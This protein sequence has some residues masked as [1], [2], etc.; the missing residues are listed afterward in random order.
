MYK[1]NKANKYLIFILACIL[2]LP[3]LVSCQPSELEVST[4]DGTL[5]ANDIA[6]FTFYYPSEFTLDK[7]ASMISVYASDNEL[8]QTDIEDNGEAYHALVHPNFSAAV[9]AFEGE[10]YESV[11]DYWERGCVP[12]MKSTFSGFEIS[13]RQDLTIDGSEAKRYD[14][15]ATL[16]GMEFK[17]SQILLLRGKNL[18]MLT[19][20]STPQKFD[21]YVTVLDTAIRTFR[22]K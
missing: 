8:V 4:A 17:Y 21:K 18:Y 11:D 22:F 20:T 19:Y 2:C 10:L 13:D 1:A 12:M 5:A 9:S 15:T 6:D 16:A 14:Y 7:N 3:V